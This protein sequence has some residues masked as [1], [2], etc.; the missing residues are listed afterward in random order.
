MDDMSNVEENRLW[1]DGYY[2]GYDKGRED[3][4]HEMRHK[5]RSLANIR[6]AAELLNNMIANKKKRNHECIK[7]IYR[8]CEGSQEGSE[9]VL[10]DALDGQSDEG[11]AAGEGGG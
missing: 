10:P 3:V 9:G 6:Q 11:E 8:E 1:C 2:C 4:L 7:G 5:L